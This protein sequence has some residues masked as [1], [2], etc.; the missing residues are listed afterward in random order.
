MDHVSL[1]IHW[2]LEQSFPTVGP[3]NISAFWAFIKC[4]QKINF[5]NIFINQLVL[6]YEIGNRKSLIQF[7]VYLLKFVI[8]WTAVDSPMS[9]DL[10]FKLFF[11]LGIIHKWC[12]ANLDL[13]PLC[14]ACMPY[15]LYV[16]QSLPPPPI[17]VM[18]FMNNPLF[19]NGRLIYY[20]VVTIKFDKCN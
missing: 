6:G 16:T 17:C 1:F 20:N 5:I 10:K 13:Y 11:D 19:E 8:H 9:T 14:H 3:T 2:P 7:H 15:A 4:Y 18:S 12:H